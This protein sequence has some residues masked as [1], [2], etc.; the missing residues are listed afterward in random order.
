MLLKFLVYNNSKKLLL[1]IQGS[2]LFQINLFKIHI[3]DK[4]KN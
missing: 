1:V 2:V 3:L 4:E